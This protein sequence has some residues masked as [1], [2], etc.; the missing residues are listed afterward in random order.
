[1]LKK[2]V[3]LEKNRTTKKNKIQQK[4]KKANK[5]HIIAFGETCIKKK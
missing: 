5:K 3:I 4:T 1:M 2:K